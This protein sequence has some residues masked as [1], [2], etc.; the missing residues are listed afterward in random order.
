MNPPSSSL[1]KIG[2]AK[3]R[4]K[5]QRR[6]AL[7]VTYDLPSS[8]RLQIAAIAE[9]GQFPAG[10]LVAAL[11]AEGL[12]RLEAGEIDLSQYTIP[13]HSHRYTLNLDLWDSPRMRK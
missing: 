3:Q 10:Q 1:S 2:Q 5:I 13:F 11:L 4:Q 7:Q 6:H 9:K 12:K 8:I